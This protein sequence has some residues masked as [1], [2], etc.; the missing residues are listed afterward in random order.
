MSITED[1]K[2]VCCGY[3]VPTLVLGFAVAILFLAVDNLAPQTMFFLNDQALESAVG[4]LNARGE[5]SLL[6]PPAALGGRHPGPYFYYWEGLLSLLSGKD[7]FAAA[8]LGTVLKALGLLLFFGAIARR[9]KAQ[10]DFSLTFSF[11]SLSALAGMWWWIL[12]VPWHSNMLF[13]ISAAAI[14]SLFSFAAG[15]VTALGSTIVFTSLLAATHFAAWPAAASILAT[16]LTIGSQTSYRAKIK[17]WVYSR[18][19]VLPLLVCLIIW[20]PSVCY[21]IEFHTSFLPFAGK[22]ASHGRVAGWL[23]AAEL[24]ARNWRIYTLGDSMQWRFAK[25]IATPYSAVVF[26]LG[27]Y[28]ALRRRGPLRTLYILFLFTAIFYLP[29]LAQI[30]SPLKLHYLQSLALLPGLALALVIAE[31][32]TVSASRTRRCFS[33]PF[34]ALGFLC[35]L[36]GAVANLSGAARPNLSSYVTMAHAAEVAQLIRSQ[37]EP[38]ASCNAIS[39]RARGDARSRENGYLLFLG[40]EYYYQM[41]DAR[42]LREHRL[43]QA[44][45]TVWPHEETVFTISCGEDSA[46]GNVDVSRC[47]T[48]TLCTINRTQEVE[49]AGE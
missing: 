15:T 8:Y 34:S 10:A 27:A 9:C 26:V 46:P 39:V 41:K 32:A 17:D 40:E 35:L 6:G 25:A 5:A 30:K 11:L 23:Q 48:C 4:L 12:R 16:A 7:I 1:K 2:R 29:A 14:C 18:R 36:D 13:L 24:L 22:K 42:K 33:I 21:S 37:C 28:F 49:T 47:S 19:I 43:F 45:R 20:L 44:G 3:K 31:A 38:P